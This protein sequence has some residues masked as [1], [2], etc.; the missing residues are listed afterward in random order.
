MG[1]KKCTKQ[2]LHILSSEVCIWEQMTEQILNSILDFCFKNNLISQVQLR[3]YVLA[4]TNT[5]S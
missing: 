5:L 4:L 2:A 3:L 1:K